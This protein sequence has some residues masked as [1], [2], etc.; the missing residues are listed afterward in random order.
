[1]DAVRDLSVT[2]TGIDTNQISSVDKRNLCSSFLAA[3]QRFYDDPHN[4]DR[5]ERWKSER[6]AH[7][8]VQRK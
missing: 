5:F 8:H 2:H 6:D 4:R 7:Y 1:M 3:V